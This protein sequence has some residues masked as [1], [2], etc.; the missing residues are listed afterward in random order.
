MSR[1]VCAE[2]QGA[3]AMDALGRLDPIERDSLHAHLGD[4][5]ACRDASTELRETVAGLE[6]VAH[7]NDAPGLLVP[8]ALSDAVLGDLDHEQRALRSR[9]LGRTVALGAGGAV[10]AGLVIVALV[11][12]LTGD[13]GVGSRTL[14]LH[15]TSSAEA[16]AVLV[17]KPWGTSLGFH[18]RGLAAGGTY[19]VSMSS[20][21]GT[22]WTAG[23]YR[24]TPAGE[25]DA[26]MACAVELRSIS[27][28]RVTD[29]AGNTVL[30]S[31][32]G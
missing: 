31:Y 9:R 30:S 8:R 27:G 10:A 7:P 29:A 12:G 17:S 14:V 2:W 19:T 1:T 18:E 24:T 21:S 16:T 15:G 23:T 4:C 11:I 5:A 20:T 32:S 26:T 6:R 3:L 13:A 22:W 28:I 25:V